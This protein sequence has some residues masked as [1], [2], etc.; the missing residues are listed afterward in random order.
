MVFNKIPSMTQNKTIHNLKDE[1]DFMAF[2]NWQEWKSDLSILISTICA[3]TTVSGQGM[4]INYITRHAP[5]KR[6]INKL[7]LI[8]QVSTIETFNYLNLC[9]IKGGGDHFLHHFFSFHFYMNGAKGPK[10]LECRKNVARSP[11]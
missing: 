4:I 3:V 5:K 8:D 10:I 6:P 7:V 9:Q 2:D 11:Q 1:D